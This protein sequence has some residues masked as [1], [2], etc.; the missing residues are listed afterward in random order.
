MRSGVWPRFPRG[1]ISRSFFKIPLSL[2]RFSPRQ[3]LAESGEVTLFAL[4]RIVN[5][6]L[7]GVSLHNRR[8][9]LRGLRFRHSL[10]A[11]KLTPRAGR[12]PRLRTL[13]ICRQYPSRHTRQVASYCET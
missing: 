5:I 4:R 12:A 11:G 13:Y 7:V 3:S 8:S 10:P 9:R 2:P 1:K 6:A